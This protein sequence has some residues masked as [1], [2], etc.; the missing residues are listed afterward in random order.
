M[1]KACVVTIPKPG[2]DH[3]TPSNFRPIL[4]LNTDIKLYAKILAHRLLPI[5]PL[6]I[7]PDQSGFT[8]GRQ[9]LDATR[10]V[11][12]IIQYPKSCRIPSL[13]L[14]LDEEKAFNRIHSGYMTHT[15]KRFG[16][17]GPILSA[18]LAL[19]SLPCAHVYTSNILSQPFHMSNGTRQG[20]PLSPSIF[21]LLIEPLAEKIRA[22]PKISGFSLQD[23]SHN[24]NL[25]ADYITLFITAPSQSLPHAHGIL[26]SFR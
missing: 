20:C 2:K 9:A 6:L 5:L 22:H 12:N 25:F 11:I 16:F 8:S 19:Y 7:N 13:L 26:N 3:T 21:N 24:I 4:L 1:L 23:N 18:I 10:R 14:S 17:T 15:L